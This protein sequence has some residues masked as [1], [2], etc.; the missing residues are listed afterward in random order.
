MRERESGGGGGGRE[1]KLADMP[2]LLQPEDEEEPVEAC[3]L[4]CEPPPGQGTAPS[5]QSALR[6]HSNLKNWRNGGYFFHL[7]MAVGYNL[8]FSIM[9]Y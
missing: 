2:S 3:V 6:R 7:V 9:S 4:N 1:T 5:G 8:S